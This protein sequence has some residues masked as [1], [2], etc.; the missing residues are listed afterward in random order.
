MQNMWWLNCFSEV[1]VRLLLFQ[2]TPP[3][4]P[5]KD[6]HDDKAVWGTHVDMETQKGLG[7]FGVWERKLRYM[8][9]VVDTIVIFKY[10]KG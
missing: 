4:S 10:L 3:V 1:Y 9:T 6:D 2:V 5:K 7:V 8:S